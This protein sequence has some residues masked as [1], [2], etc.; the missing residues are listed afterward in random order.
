MSGSDEELH[1]LQK[2]YQALVDYIKH[3]HMLSRNH[4]ADRVLG[5]I[6]EKIKEFEEYYK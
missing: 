4:I 1:K 2:K 6:L 5:N 3:M